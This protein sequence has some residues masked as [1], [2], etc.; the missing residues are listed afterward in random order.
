MADETRRSVSDSLDSNQIVLPFL[1]FL[2]QDLWAL[3]S[4]VESIIRCV[5]ALPFKPGR[6]GVLDLGCGKGAVLIRIARE[7]GFRVV[8]ID[9]ME[10]FIHDARDRSRQHQ[11][12]HLCTFEHQD[13]HDYLQYPHDFD[14]VILASLGSVLGMWPETVSALRRQ[15]RTGGYIIIDDGYLHTTENLHRKGYAHYRDHDRTIRELTSRGDRIFAEMSTATA[16]EQINR[17]YLQ[18]I[19]RRGDELTRIHPKLRT[20]LMEYIALQE[21]ECRVIAEHIAG[22]LWVVQKVETSK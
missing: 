20:A 15:I 2:L 10:D 17:E 19:R 9:A 18:V 13:M 8:G 1:P 22:A 11:V 7:F 3:G 21:E 6:A 5:G 16:T 14:I 12:D 4:D